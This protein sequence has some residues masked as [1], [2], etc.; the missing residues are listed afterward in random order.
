MAARRGCRVELAGTRV[1]VH[2]PKKP[3]LWTCGPRS[4]PGSSAVHVISP[5]GLGCG[6]RRGEEWSLCDGVEAYGMV[7][8]TSDSLVFGGGGDWRCSPKAML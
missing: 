6:M 2:R 8:V 7:L 1:R 4:R 3:A 5:G